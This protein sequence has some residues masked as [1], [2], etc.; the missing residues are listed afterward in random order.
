MRGLP[1][2]RSIDLTLCR[3]VRAW[4]SEIPTWLRSL[5]L[6]FRWLGETG[7]LAVDSIRAEGTI[8]SARIGDEPQPLPLP[9]FFGLLGFTGFPGGLSCPGGFCE[10]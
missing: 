3:C 6:D 9:F 10:G 7:H 2:R 1:A 4:L 5:T 8:T